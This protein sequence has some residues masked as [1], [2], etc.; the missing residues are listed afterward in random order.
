ML[1]RTPDNLVVDFGNTPLAEV[2]SR[3]LQRYPTL[4]RQEAGVAPV[5]GGVGAPVARITASGAEGY[6]PLG[7]NILE[8]PD[9]AAT[10][11]R[12]TADLAQLAAGRVADASG[13]P[14]GIFESFRRGGAAAL[15]GLGQAGAAVTG[16]EAEAAPSDRPGGEGY[17]WGDLLRPG[18]LTNKLA[19]D[20]AAQ[21]PTLAGGLAGGAAGEAVAGPLG[22]VLGG[23]AGAG[24]ASAAQA[25]GPYY[26]DELK[27]LHQKGGQPTPADYDRA[28]EAAG[29]KAVQDGAFST[30]GW[31]AFSFGPKGFL[32]NLLFQA[33]GVQQGVAA[34]ETAVKNYEAG[35]KLTAGMG[36][37]IPGVAIGTAIP[38]AAFHAL[39]GRDPA[40]AAVR[41]LY[42]EVERRK[43]AE[44]VEPP[45]PAAPV[46]GARDTLPAG[47]P[48]NQAL[49]NAERA[50]GLG[51][52]TIAATW[53][54]IA[55]K[56]AK[57]AGIDIT[58]VSRKPL[59]TIETP[60]GKVFSARTPEETHYD[61]M[62]R[63]LDEGHLTPEEAGKLDEE[64][65]TTRM[66]EKLAPE[67]PAAGGVPPP[68]P[69]GG[70]PR[71]PADMG[72]PPGPVAGPP[73][74]HSAEAHGA[75]RS[76]V[77]LL[78]KG[79]SPATAGRSEA[80]YGRFNPL[81]EDIRREVGLSGREAA[82]AKASLV[83]FLRKFNRLPEGWDAARGVTSAVKP[84]GDTQLSW[85]DYVEGGKEAPRDPELRKAAEA[86]RKAAA[87]V[88]AELSRLPKYAQRQW[89]EHYL[90]HLW[91]ENDEIN[92][93][94]NA[95]SSSV[96]AKLGT[97]RY[98]R[99]RKIATISE[100]IR[101]GWTPK[102]DNIFEGLFKY[103]E[104]M[105]RHVA[106]EKIVQKLRDQ[107]E[108]TW[109]HGDVLPPG[110]TFLNGVFDATGAKGA[111]ADADKAMNFNNYTSRGFHGRTA[112][113]A[114]LGPI[115][116]GIHSMTN[117]STRTAL[118][119]SGYHA[120][121]TAVTAMSDRMGRALAQLFTGH[122]L[123]AASSLGKV[124]TAPFDYAL[125]GR[126][127]TQQYLR[128]ADYGPRLE[129]VVKQAAIANARI[130]DRNIDF[131][132]TSAGSLI[133]AAKQGALSKQ[134]ANDWRLFK[135]DPV[136]QALPV[137]AK[138]F[139]RILDTAS[140]WLFDHYIP[141]LKN[142]A[143]YYNMSDYIDRH[144]FATPD[145]L[146]RAARAFVDSIDN[147]FGE[148]MKDNLFWHALPRQIA[149]MAMLSD[150]WQIGL[151]REF[152]GAGLDV[153][154]AM[155]HLDPKYLSTRVTYTLGF[156]TVSA[157]LGAT[158]AVL[159]GGKKAGDLTMQDLAAPPT[160]GQNQ[161]GTPE[162]FQIPGHSKD[163]FEWYDA[164]TSLS[165]TKVLHVM[166]NKANPLWS[167]LVEGMT[168]T[169]WK[170]QLVNPTNDFGKA[171]V[172]TMQNVA[173]HFTPIVVQQYTQGHPKG[174]KFSAVTDILGLKPALRGLNEPALAE[175]SEVLGRFKNLSETL[176]SDRSIANKNP[177]PANKA[178]VAQDQA[179][180]VELRQQLRKANLKYQESLPQPGYQG[181]VAPQQ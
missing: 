168:G 86:W 59:R 72:E 61:V 144:P 66:P 69:P 109:H 64:H 23:A 102:F 181:T 114:E 154:R 52:E 62:Q 176:K 112:A 105:H 37:E 96:S 56:R 100:G 89:R 30:V 16:G 161:D 106:K 31:A 146:D 76:M 36:E 32:K 55:R 82:A 33:F 54:N 79:L 83:P 134:L 180:M 29:A 137:I 152:A 14:P 130:A 58:Q 4:Q 88:E 115:Y 120:L 179:D 75:V 38:L 165:P 148:M 139:G 6:L 163:L 95:N 142:G 171:V 2:K 125:A 104:D 12:K 175:R 122:P 39:K 162:R 103:L 40:K 118:A 156:M 13:A 129:K 160:G 126:K 97:G 119:F 81:S 145:D 111:I 117:A 7:R 45:T 99:E 173:E 80:V 5:P 136:K 177:S 166:S 140:A 18:M 57:D 15:R 170:G 150:S 93:A 77:T 19:Y 17:Q 90:T 8:K 157:L 85:A 27:K 60:D 47:H 35:R 153:G 138:N 44:P 98:T 63:A 135:S 42:Q 53:E 123:K 68:V 178:K 158:I 164:I 132:A 172:R 167:N 34:A 84:A 10:L 67:S 121:N 11:P 94:R 169:N 155:R 43:Q 107:G 28:F 24:L 51:Q 141:A 110:W 41:K 151:F 26:A 143:L 25:L 92:A 127:L 91:K 174:S 131:S 74:I 128:L 124:I 149:Q 116:D 87:D 3:L 65:F 9:P 21:V 108:I 20:L 73:S 159:A 133:K 1:V 147:R 78:Q 48:V 50:R 46:T 49:A 71:G 22:G 101:A 70:P 113:G